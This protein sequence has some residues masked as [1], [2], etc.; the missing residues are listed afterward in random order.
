MIGRRVRVACAAL[1]LSPGTLALHGAE[2]VELRRQGDHIDVLV[3][4]KAFTTYYFGS[5]SP[6]AYLHPLRSAH[7]TVVTRG[8]PM[9]KDIPGESHDHPH[10]RA[11]F[12]AHGDINGVDFWGEGQPNRASQTAQGQFY[13]S[14]ELPKGRTVFRQL[15]EA[16]GNIIRAQFDLVGPDGK[17]MGEETQVM[18]SAAMSLPASSTAPLSSPP[19]T[20]R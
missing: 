18:F 13:S 5:D 7:G 20:V 3:E 2:A 12:F 10:H 4:E 1:L 6:K 15:D 19:T 8:W 11:M 17:V 9:V 16:T 14:E